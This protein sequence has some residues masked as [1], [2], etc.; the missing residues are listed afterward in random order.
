VAAV[1]TQAEGRPE[2]RLIH[3]VLLRSMQQ[4]RYDILPLGHFG[5]A[6]DCYTHFTSPIRRYPDLVIHRL[7]DVALRRA[8]RVPPDLADIAAAA[9]GRERIAMEAEREIVQLKKIQFMQDKV[10]QTYSGFISGTANFGLFVEL[11]DVFVEGLV[12]VTALGD[13]FYQHDE[14]AHCLRGR[15]SRRAFRLGDPIRVIVAGVSVERRQ[16]DF[17]L[18]DQET[19]SRRAPRRRGGWR[20]RQHS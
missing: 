17:A 16:I 20:R 4:A 7:L 19:G 12:H 1:L 6:T 8:G 2:A 11:A 14:Q 9:S 18:G 13:D 3:T 15:R 5:L 10:G